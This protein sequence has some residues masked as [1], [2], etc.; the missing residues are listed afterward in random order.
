MVVQDKIVY[1]NNKKL[2]KNCRFPPQLWK[3]YTL[4]NFDMMNICIEAAATKLIRSEQMASASA[5]RVSNMPYRPSIRGEIEVRG[6]GSQ[7][8]PRGQGV[9]DLVATV[10][11]TYRVENSS[12]SRPKFFALNLFQCRDRYILLLVLHFSGFVA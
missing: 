7:P 4:T 2:I 12:T 3:C 11:S 8:L 9:M 10:C 5:A 1:A 6:S